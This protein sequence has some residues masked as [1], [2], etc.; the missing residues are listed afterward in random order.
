MATWRVK[1]Q[2]LQDDG[3]PLTGA[4]GLLLTI[5]READGYFLDFDDDTFKASPTTES[6]AMD[7]VNSTIVPGLYDKDLTTTAWDNGRYNAYVR[8]LTDPTRYGIAETHLIGGNENIASH[9]IPGAGSL[10]PV[11]TVTNTVAV[12]IENV[13]VWAT[14]DSAGTRIVSS[15]LTDAGGEVEL[16]L[17]ASITYYLWIA[18]AGYTATSYPYS[19]VFTSGDLAATLTMSLVT[20]GAGVATSSTLRQMISQCAALMGDLKHDDYPRALYVDWLNQAQNEMLRLTNKHLSHL[21]IEPL[22]QKE[23][24]VAGA[25]DF[26]TIENGGNLANNKPLLGGSWNILTVQLF[27]GK[28]CHLMAQDEYD[29]KSRV[30]KVY[31]VDD[32][33]YYVR[34]SKVYVEPFSD[35]ADNLTEIDFVYV[36]RPAQMAL[37]LDPADD[38][39]CEFEDDL[40]ECIIGLALVDFVNDNTRVAARYAQALGIIKRLNDTARSTDSIRKDQA[41]LNKS[42]VLRLSDFIRVEDT[43]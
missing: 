5:E 20:T 18:K 34:G 32:P 30:D 8:H 7:E 22:T 10:A 37:A 29:E 33:A 38:T 40:R 3:T 27:G 6:E 1:Y 36:R 15:G 31:D 14:L 16:Y 25:F 21:L 35:D 13:H 23:L 41:S 19:E 26:R 12:P 39:L 42:S 43:V 2:L 24:T 28:P 11:V 17:D 9:H 4:S